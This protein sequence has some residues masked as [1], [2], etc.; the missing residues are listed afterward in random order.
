M[1]PFLLILSVLFTGL[2]ASVTTKYSPEMIKKQFE[3]CNLDEIK[4]F[5]VLKAAWNNGEL[6]SN[7]KK[8]FFALLTR[9]EKSI[10]RFFISYPSPRMLPYLN[11]SSIDFRFLIGYFYHLPGVGQ[12]P[13]LNWSLLL[14]SDDIFRMIP[15]PAKLL[16]DKISG[17]LSVLFERIHSLTMK[18]PCKES[19]N[20]IKNLLV[21]FE[22]L[23]D[24]YQKLS[25]YRFESINPNYLALGQFWKSNLS[26]LDR[27]SSF[28]LRAEL[29][30][31]VCNL[32]TT[33]EKNGD[34]LR[35]EKLQK[36]I[37]LDI[38]VCRFY[39][40]EQFSSED[41]VPLGLISIEDTIQEQYFTS[42]Q[43]LLIFISHKYK[44]NYVKMHDL[45]TDFLEGHKSCLIEMIKELPIFSKK[46]FQS[47]QPNEQQKILKFMRDLEKLIPSTFWNLLE[48]QLWDY[49]TE[50]NQKLFN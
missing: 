41:Q 19:I 45:I 18:E 34:N 17:A 25:L 39:N 15:D 13:K 6:P 37:Y 23:S 29:Y 26:I 5:E 35:E 1:I 14:F 24:V 10:N 47:Y 20:E 16:I 48:D 8:I 44:G 49:L 11:S 9:F 12:F 2:L 43:I 36:L 27:I 40:Q 33:F 31:V 28:Q 50:I 38:L 46:I 7:C 4:E 30:Y 42:Q 21:S 3:L 32:W 22:K